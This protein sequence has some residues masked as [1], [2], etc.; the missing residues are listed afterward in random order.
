MQLN[1]TRTMESRRWR[2]EIA[3]VERREEGQW[4]ANVKCE[5]AIPTATIG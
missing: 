5:F 4:T 3:K 1:G 2:E